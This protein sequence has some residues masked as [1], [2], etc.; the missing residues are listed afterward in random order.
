MTPKT[1]KTLLY[2]GGGALAVVIILVLVFGVQEALAGLAALVTLVFGGWF[3]NRR[4]EKR[5]ADL[6]IVH[7]AQDTVTE[8]RA[9]LKIIAQETDRERTE[10]AD[11][12]AKL[13]PEAKARLG[14]DLLGDE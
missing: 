13:D 4:D 3:A 14:D 5:Q 2:A 12:L 8:G 10:A 1:R 6:E 11:D 7:D 9:D